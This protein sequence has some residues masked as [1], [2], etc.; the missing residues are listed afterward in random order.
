MSDVIFHYGK[1]EAQIESAYSKIDAEKVIERIW[2]K[3]YTVWS[4]NPA[5][6]SNRLGWL[7]SPSQ[8]KDSIKDINDFV[9]EVR[10]EGFE[11]A[12]LLGM[13]GSSLAPEV[14]SR[15][16]GTAKGYLNLF[17]LDSTHPDNVDELIRKLDPRKTL[18]IVSTKSG[19]TIETISFM[20]F[21]YSHVAKNIGSNEAGKH[22]LAITDP[23]SGLED[24]AKKLHYRKIFLN[25]PDIGG[26][27]SAISM[28]GLVPA[29]L[30]GVN[31][32]K[33]LVEAYKLIE[34]SKKGILSNSSAKVGAFAGV[35]ANNGID[36][37]TYIISK[38]LYPF[39]VWV[40]QLIAE[41]TGKIGKG[42]LPVEGEKIL[43]LS[44]YNKDKVFVY[45][46]LQNE[47]E[48]SNEVRELLKAGFPVITI[49][50]A[51]RYEL[52]A[53]FFRWE[54]ATAVIGRLLE[55][56]PFDQPDVE[57]AKIIARET[58]KAYQKE[59]K[60]PLL[61]TTL[62]EDGIDVVSEFNAVTLKSTLD[63]F[64][65]KNLDKQNGYVSIQAYVKND[66][67]TI[68]ALQKLRD[69]I[70]EKYPVSTTIGIGPRFLHST[71]QLHKGDKG[72][73]VFIQF[74]APNKSDYNIPEEPL[75]ESSSFS[76]G[77]LVN[78]QS[79]GDRQALLNK[80]RKVIRFTSADIVKCITRLTELIKLS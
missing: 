79:L 60:L 27:F 74:F 80:G 53:E 7:D 42:I 28:F 54:F 63:Q 52:C 58:I 43:D 36:K 78:A 12:L 22:F 6:I 61:E 23:G 29:A 31:I 55:V 48:Y 70:Q 1:E 17:V 51:D 24:Y 77:V 44:T 59:G 64:F 68:T 62:S 40:E 76:F 9:E 5:E 45:L 20:K 32:E 66:E 72:N 4:E 35:L 69:A 71:G 41:S 16:F 26:R 34:E 37:L 75:S 11:N 33:L 14:F 25:N 19:G 13:G 30:L 49:E 18:Y 67:T 65:E 57:S 46:R 50:M 15:I 47:T 38:S 2:K 73:G 21:F 3:D 39:G 10:K 8:M 56:Q